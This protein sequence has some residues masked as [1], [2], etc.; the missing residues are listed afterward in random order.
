[1]DRGAEG[2]AAARHVLRPHELPDQAREVGGGDAGGRGSGG[3]GPTHPC[4]NTQQQ[5]EA[6]CES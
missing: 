6:R 2:E 5:S 4:K 1:M 3:A